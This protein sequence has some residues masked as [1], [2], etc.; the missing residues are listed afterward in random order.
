M[1]A[2]GGGRRGVPG[3]PRRSRK[4]S[5]QVRGEWSTQDV[6]IDDREVLP[7]WSLRVRL[8]SPAGFSWGYGGSEP[9]QLALA[10]CLEI[11]TEEMA[12]LWYQE[13]K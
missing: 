8:Y 2:D 9:T 6:W 10:L 3:S 11:T 13:V 4:C 1:K 12:L 5:L 7:E